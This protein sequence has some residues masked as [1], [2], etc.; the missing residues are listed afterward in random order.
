MPLIAAPL[1][2]ELRI[3]KVAADDKTRRHLESLG[4][5]AGSK[6]TALS[7]SAGNVIVRIRES[8]LALNRQL[9]A[10]ITVTV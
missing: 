10:K 1:N 6:L 3:E 7:F 5:I 9:A 4:L 8:R 2:L